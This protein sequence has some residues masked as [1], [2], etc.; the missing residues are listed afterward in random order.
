MQKEQITDKEAICLLIVFVIGTSLIIGSGG[1]AKNDA[2]LAGIIGV[3]MAIPVLLV[4]SRTV[5]LFQG[6]DL[7]DIL[8]ITDRKSVV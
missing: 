5:S 8:N 4:Y 3:I 2:W 7:F 1:D 6:H